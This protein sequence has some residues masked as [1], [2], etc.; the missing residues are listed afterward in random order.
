MI[1][2]LGIFIVRS[3]NF[4]CSL[5]HAKR[6]FI[7]IIIIIIIYFRSTHFRHA[8]TTMSAKT[9]RTVTATTSLLRYVMYFRFYGWRHVWPQWAVWRCVSTTGGV[10][11]PGHGLMSINAL[12]ATCH[13]K[14]L[15]EYI[16]RGLNVCYMYPWHVDQR[17]PDFTQMTLT[18]SAYIWTDYRTP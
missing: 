17:Q 2:Y 13:F 10:A 14:F 4:R 7:I 5:D 11:I 12:F 8:I 9:S 6:S 1:R 15:R 16:Y 3:T 18:K